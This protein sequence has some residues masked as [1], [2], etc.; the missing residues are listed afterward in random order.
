MPIKEL[1]DIRRLPRIGKIHLGIWKTSERTNKEYPTATDYF[2]VH[3]NT[4][5]T[6]AEAA[7]AFHQVYGDEPRELDVMFPSDDPHMIFPQWL[8]AYRSVGLFCKGDGEVATRRAEDGSL[9]EMDC[10]CELLESGDCKRVGSLV[11]LLPRV[12]GLGVW[13]LDTSSFHSIVQVN[14][15]I[16]FIKILTGGRIAML[17][18]KLRLRPKEVTIYTADG[19][20]GK[21]HPIKKTVFTLDLVQEQVTLANILSAAST[22]LTMALRPPSTAVLE[23]EA[24]EDLFPTGLSRSSDSRADAT[25]VDVTT[26]EILDE[27]PL[28]PEGDIAPPPPMSDKDAITAIF[29]RGLELGFSPPQTLVALGVSTMTLWF[30]QGKPVQDAI[31][32]LETLAE[33]RRINKAKPKE[34]KEEAK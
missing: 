12:S 34:K 25:T 32:A 2:V 27:I 13:Q 24:P 15:G 1:S 8:K 21:L 10:P 3:S 31:A 14:S 30:D 29:N 20:T 17:P 4:E 22:P 5:T 33:K 6:S 9:F 18:L 26:G 23:Q 11:F 16:D 7:E 28:P 19:Q